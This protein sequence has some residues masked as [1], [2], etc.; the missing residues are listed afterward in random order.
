ML[1]IGLI[2]GAAAP[3]A[4]D[5]H[6]NAGPRKVVVNQAYEEVRWSVG[7]SDSLS[8][9]DADA[10]LEHAATRDWADWDYA[11]AAPFSGTLRIDGYSPMGRYQVYGDV[12]DYDYNEMAATPAYVTVKRASHA[13]LS[14]TRSQGRLNLT[15]VTRRYTGSYPSWGAHRGA[16]IRF[17][18]KIG[19]NWRT[20]ASRKVA[21]NGV[22]T[23]RFR[24]SAR[25]YRVVVVETAAVWG[26]TSGMLRR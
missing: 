22:N 11:T 8:V 16:T 12:Y 9:E 18:R 2:A 10:T 1:S 25:T 4:A 17:Q 19:A 3:A 20:F 6:Y 7:G 14:A 26:S 24:A 13:K 21:S 5:L 15:A 23:L